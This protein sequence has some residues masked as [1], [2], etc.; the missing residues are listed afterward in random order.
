MSAEAVQAV[1]EALVDHTRLSMDGRCSCGHV[2]PLGHSFA[3]HQAEAAVA[4]ARP[5]IEREAKAEVLRE[6]AALADAVIRE[7]RAAPSLYP[8]IPGASEAALRAAGA[9]HT[10]EVLHRRMTRAFADRIERE[11][12]A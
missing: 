1:A 5:T 9:R 10:L 3:E 12:Q 6:G 11:G 4:A 8:T 7:W 2:V